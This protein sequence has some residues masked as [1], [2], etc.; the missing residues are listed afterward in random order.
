MTV[1][2]PTLQRCRWHSAAAAC[3]VLVA[4]LVGAPVA[5]ADDP[6]PPPQG[7]NPQWDTLAQAC[8]DGVW[9]SCDDL[10]A[11]TQPLVGSD[12][13]AF[14]YNLY[15]LRCGGRVVDWLYGTYDCGAPA[16]TCVQM[17]RPCH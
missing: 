5:G 12:Q 7:N 13:K 6:S 4:A 3:A 10:V 16:V 14:D 11:Q 8:H 9:Q 2:I 1:A 15:G 17:Y